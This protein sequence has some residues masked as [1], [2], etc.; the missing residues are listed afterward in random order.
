MSVQQILRMP[1]I[2]VQ[3]LPSAD[4]G[5]HLIL[6]PRCGSD[7]DPPAKPGGLHPLRLADKERLAL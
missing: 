7:D 3:A 2:T 4:P 1:P 6:L 5:D